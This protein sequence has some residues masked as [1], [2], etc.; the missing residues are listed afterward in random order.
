MAGILQPV[1]QLAGER[2]LTGALKAGEH[3][4]RRRILCEVQRAVHT[5]AK[6]RGELLIDNL[7]DLLGRVERFGNLGAERAFADPA[8]EGTH[9]VERHIGVEQRA[10]DLA[11]G[12]V[13]IS[14]G[15]LAF[16]LQML[17]RI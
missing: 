1:T 15:K 5:G 6:H 11:D 9:H 2:R 10:A 14:L 8:G 7:H 17:E 16:A 13:D 4:D 12:A 3:D